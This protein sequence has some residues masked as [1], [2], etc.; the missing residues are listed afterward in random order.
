MK[1][2]DTLK[3]VVTHDGPAASGKKRQRA[4]RANAFFS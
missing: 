2:C 4:V 3:E 1:S